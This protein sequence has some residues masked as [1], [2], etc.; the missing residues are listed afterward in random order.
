MALAR[1]SGLGLG[2]L[3]L[4]QS[5]AAVA[6][7]PAT[8]GQAAVVV[9]DVKGAIGAK[10]T[11]L[12]V[13]DD[14]VFQEVI[15]AGD[16]SAALAR[17]IDSTVLSIGSN[18]RVTLDDFVVPA[19]GRKPAM[20]LTLAQGVLRLV[21]GTMVGGVYRARTPTAAV[22]VRGT[23]FDLITEPD[24]ATVIYVEDGTATFANLSGVS[25][26]V[27][28]GLASRIDARSGPPSPPQPPSAGTQAAVAAMMTKLALEAP[29]GD[30]LPATAIDSV[31]ARAAAAA[32]L[33][34]KTS[35]DSPGGGL[36]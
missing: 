13:G 4:L 6:E 30:V 34:A 7:Q 12:K 36:K 33:A 19:A 21:T 18:S 16:H 22:G 28:A 14:L 23:V 31:A 5:G 25:V 3:L 11:P 27:S 32:A 10:S 8:V 1:F 35:Q 17:F 20:A 29:P 26:D 9:R 2:T 24:G 15:A